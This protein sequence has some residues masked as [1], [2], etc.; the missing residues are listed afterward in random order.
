VRKELNSLIPENND[1]I[2]PK[3]SKQSQASSSSTVISLRFDKAGLERLDLLAEYY[4]KLGEIKDK[5]RSEVIRYAL[6]CLWAGTRRMIE[7][8]RYGE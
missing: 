8:R 4:F 1:V 5:K 6:N 3:G 7:R 2:M